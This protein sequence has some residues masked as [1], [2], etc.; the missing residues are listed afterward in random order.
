MPAGKELSK[1]EKGTILGL[2]KA[3]YSNLK[4]A[5]EIN[6]SEKAVRTVVRDPDG[7]NRRPRTGRPKILSPRARRQMFRL[8][9]KQGMSSAKIKSTINLSCSRSTVCR[10]QWDTEIAKYVKR[11][12][13]PALMSDHKLRR[14]SFAQEKAIS[15]FDW[16]RV[17][18]SDEKKFNLDGPDGCQ[19]Y[20]HD[21]RLPPEIFSK[22]VASGGSVMVWAVIS[23]HGTSEIKILEGRLNQD[24]AGF[25]RA[26]VVKAWL[27]DENI[28]TMSWTA[29]SPDLSPI[30]NLWADLVL[31]V[32]ANG[33]QFETVEELR[34]QVLL[35]WA[36]VKLERLQSLV[37][38]M[39]TRMALVLRSAGA[40]INR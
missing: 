24:G 29:K 18:F 17:L 14:V 15:Y 9:C 1:R 10:A 25:H 6:R 23:A 8:A 3:G 12:A 5:K 34:A 7:Q 22:R 31:S 19:F 32:Y 33:R 35:S 27:E 28:S 21:S 11:K 30:E 2:K 38:D 39:P 4:I 37:D 16:K 20:W 13:A 26:H 40:K 36:Q